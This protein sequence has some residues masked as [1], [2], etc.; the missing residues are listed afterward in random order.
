MTRW[1]VAESEWKELNARQRAYMV[2]IF[3]EDQRREA[4]ARL[5][6]TASKQ[7]GGAAEW[8]K[9]PFTIQADPAFTGYTEVQA[10]LRD[11]GHLDAGAG[12][13]LQALARRALIAI[14]VDQVE[15]AP[16]G[17][18]P[19]TLVELTRHG[20]AVVRVG[21][22][23]PTPQRRPTHLLS[24]WLWRCLVMVAQA[25]E[26]GLSTD[27]LQGKSRFY[28]GTGYRP[29]GRLSRGYIDLVTVQEPTGDQSNVAER[30]WK[31]TDR[32]RDHM[33]KHVATYRELY[34]AIRVDHSEDPTPSD[35]SR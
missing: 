19:R 28:L 24:E 33:A 14:S 16:L 9:I 2:A 27:R 6:Q 17:F 21:L 15:V 29:Q 12:A 30:R 22:R 35:H 23:E 34:P 8:R 3:R 32:G 20:R 1:A 10:R 11:G 7:L 5:S 4:E 25:G 13:T 31:L 26:E 18:V